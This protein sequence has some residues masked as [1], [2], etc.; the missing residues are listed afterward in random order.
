MAEST[1]ESL[2]RRVESLEAALAAGN[3]T[4]TSPDWRKAVGMFA[5]SEFMKQVDEEGR[6]I[7]EAEREAAR[8]EAES[9]N[10]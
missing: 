4:K 1:L 2:E 10:T 8:R 6:R 7:N 9:E 3:P 5:G